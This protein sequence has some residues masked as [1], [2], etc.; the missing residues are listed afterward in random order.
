MLCYLS[1]FQS[2]K[3]GQSHKKNTK[4][5]VRSIGDSWLSDGVSR[6]LRRSAGDR[7]AESM[8]VSYSQAHTAQ[9]KHE[10]INHIRMPRGGK[11]PS[12]G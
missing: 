11:G 6:T 12:H 1:D 8:R 4:L 2:N 9:M 7:E 5:C 3:K 10:R